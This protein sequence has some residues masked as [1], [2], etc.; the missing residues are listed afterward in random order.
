MIRWE[1]VT[2][3]WTTAKTIWTH[4]HAF[5]Q[6]LTLWVSVWKKKNKRLHYDPGQRPDTVCV[7]EVSAS[8]CL[9]AENQLDWKKAA[10][11]KRKEKDAQKRKPI[12]VTIKPWKQTAATYQEINQWCVAKWKKTAFQPCKAWKVD[13]RK[14]IEEI[15][16]FKRFLKSNVCRVLIFWR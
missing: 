12:S 4:T 13:K 15:S 6:W 16:H 10:G 2:A 8:C 1:S 3:R 5:S 9:P 7:F 11:R 14:I